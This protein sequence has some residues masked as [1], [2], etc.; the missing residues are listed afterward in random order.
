[1]SPRIWI[2]RDW[3][4]V[5]LCIRSG[6]HVQRIRLTDDEVENLKRQLA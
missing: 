3:T 1:M 4:A 2:E 6:K 5:V